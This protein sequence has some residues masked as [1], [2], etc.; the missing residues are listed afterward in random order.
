MLRPRG[1]KDTGLSVPMTASALA[2][3]DSDA[4][5][6][7]EPGLPPFSVSVSGIGVVRLGRPRKPAASTALTNAHNSH[8]A[9]TR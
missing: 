2:H 6:V 4:A 7:L 3:K 5:G 1:R 9:D 8:K